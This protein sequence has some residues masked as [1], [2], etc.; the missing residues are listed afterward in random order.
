MKRL[1]T[2]LTVSLLAGCASNPTVPENNI[3]PVLTHTGGQ[4]LGD[5]TS[6]Y[7]FTSQQNRPVSLADRVMAGD[8]GDYRTD[9][10]WRDGKLREIKRE[11]RQLDE[12]QLKPFSLHVRYDTLGNAV[13]QRYTLGDELIPLGSRQLQQLLEEAEHGTDVVKQQRKDDQ[14]LVQGFWKQGQFYRCADQR[15]LQVNFT[16]VLP[17][18][19]QQQVQEHQQDGYMAVIGQVRRSTLTAKTLLM[20]ADDQPACLT[21]PVLLTN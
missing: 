4:S 16:P 11:G 1:L 18:Y 6:I 20:L 7:W 3:T 8:Y 19:V 2:F 12:Q 21:A 10:R 17:D 15:P 14:S 9:Y 13:F 5:S